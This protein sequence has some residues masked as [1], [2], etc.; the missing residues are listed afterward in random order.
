MP[1]ST[2]SF[3]AGTAL[4]AAVLCG[5]HGLSY[6]KHIEST[7]QDVKN[8]RD[9]PHEQACSVE[10]MRKLITT[11]QEQL[12][13]QRFWQAE[14]M[15]LVIKHI[16]V[17]TQEGKSD[18]LSVF[19]DN[20]LS[21][22]LVFVYEETKRYISQAGRDVHHEADNLMEV[23]FETINEVSEYSGAARR[24]MVEAFCARLIMLV[25]N[26]KIL[27]HTRMEAERTLNLMLEGCEDDDLT[28][29]GN[30]PVT[31]KLMQHLADIL[32]VAG[33]FEMQIA[34]TESLARMVTKSERRRRSPAWFPLQAISEAF[35]AIDDQRFDSD[36]RI[37]LNLLNES[38][39]ER[40]VCSFP[41]K[42]AFLG[43]FELRNPNEDKVSEFWV[44]FNAVSQS[45]TMY[46]ADEDTG[47]EEEGGLWETVTFSKEKV[48]EYLVNEDEKGFINLIVTLKDPASSILAFCG[49]DSRT[50]T[51]IF[52][53]RTDLADA[54]VLS[55]GSDKNAAP[56]ETPS[57]SRRSSVSKINVLVNRARNTSWG[58]SNMPQS[59]NDGYI[60]VGAHQ[61]LH[62]GK[63][64][65]TSGVMDADEA[66]ATPVRRKISIPLVPM[67][68]PTRTSLYS[69]ASSSVSSSGSV[70]CQGKQTNQGFVQ[71]KTPTG[72]HG[73]T[74]K[75][76][77]PLQVTVADKPS[78]SGTDSDHPKPQSRTPAKVSVTRNTIVCQSP[79]VSQ[80]ETE[81]KTP[82]LVANHLESASSDCDVVEQEVAV[83]KK[84]TKG[85]GDQVEISS[86]KKS[87]KQTTVNDAGKY[88]VKKGR[89]KKGKADQVVA[90]QSAPNELSQNV[91]EIPDTQ[92]QSLISQESEG[93]QGTQKTTGR[94]KGRKAATNPARD[95][96]K[97]TTRSS[98][99]S[100]AKDG[101]TA[102][103]MPQPL[104]TGSKSRGGKKFTL[105]SET[106]FLMDSSE[107]EEKNTG[108]KTR[109]KGK[110]AP[111]VSNKKSAVREM[112]E[113]EGAAPKSKGGQTKKRKKQEERKDLQDTG[114][115]SRKSEK[116]TNETQTKGKWASKK[117]IN[118]ISEPLMI[119]EEDN[120][121]Q[122]F[123][124][125]KT[126]VKGK[127]IRGVNDLKGDG[128]TTCNP[129]Y[130]PDPQEEQERQ[131]SRLPQ[132][133][134]KAAAQALAAENAE[135]CIPSSAPEERHVSSQIVP[136]SQP[137]RDFFRRSGRFPSPL[138][139]D[140]TE[141]STLSKGSSGPKLG[142]QVPQASSQSDETSELMVIKSKTKPETAKADSTSTSCNGKDP[143]DF[144]DSSSV[145]SFPVGSRKTPA[146]GS[147]DDGTSTKAQKGGEMTAAAKR[148]KGGRPVALCEE[149]GTEESSQDE[150][151]ENSHKFGL[152]N[153]GSAKSMDQGK[154]QRSAKGRKTSATS[155]HQQE[156]TET[157]DDAHE[158][159]RQS[160]R[161]KMKGK[162]DS[163][164]AYIQRIQK[165]T[166]ELAE[167]ASRMQDQEEEYPDIEVARDV[168]LVTEA[169]D[170]TDIRT[171]VKSV[172][173]SL[174]ERRMNKDVLKKPIQG[175]GKTLDRQDK[176]FDDE[177]DKE[178][179]CA[180]KKDPEVDDAECGPRRQSSSSSRKRK[181]KSISRS[182]D[183]E[184][185]G[186]VTSEPHKKTF[187][188]DI[189]RKAVE[190]AAGMST[191]SSRRSVR[192]SVKGD[193][194]LT[195]GEMSVDDMVSAHMESILGD[196]SSSIKKSTSKKAEDRMKEKR[197]ALHVEELE[198]DS[199]VLRHAE[200]SI[201][202]R[203]K[204]IVALRRSSSNM[205][206]D[207]ENNIDAEKVERKRSGDE[208]LHTSNDKSKRTTRSSMSFNQGDHALHDQVPSPKHHKERKSKYEK[209][210]LEQSDDDSMYD[211]ERDLQDLQASRKKMKQEK[212]KKQDSITNKSKK[213]TPKTTTDKTPPYSAKKKRSM[214]DNVEVHEEV[215]SRM[216]KAKPV[217][218]IDKMERSAL[219]SKVSKDRRTHFGSQIEDSDSEEIMETAT[220]TP[221]DETSTVVSVESFSS[222]C[223]D[224]LKSSRRGIAA[225]RTR[226]KV[227]KVD[228]TELENSSVGSDDH[229]DLQ[230][231]CRSAKKTCDKSTSDIYE[232]REETSSCCTTSFI[233][234]AV[235]ECSWLADKPK[236]KVSTYSKTRREVFGLAKITMN[237]DTVKKPGNKPQVKNANAP[238]KRKSK[239]L[240]DG[241][242]D[243]FPLYYYEEEKETKKTKKS[244]KKGTQQR[245]EPD[246]TIQVP[247]HQKML[248]KKPKSS[249]RRSLAD[250]MS[251]F[252]SSSI[253]HMYDS[254]QDLREDSDEGEE[255]DERGEEEKEEVEEEE[256]LITPAT[257]ALTIET[258]TSQLSC[259]NTP[260]SSTRTPRTPKQVSFV[261]ELESLG[262]DGEG[263]F[264]MDCP[265]SGPSKSIRPSESTLK[266][267]YANLLLDD[268]DE[269]IN[270]DIDED[271]SLE[272]N[273]HPEEED[274]SRSKDKNV[275][276]LNHSSKQISMLEP[277]ILFQANNL[278]DVGEQSE[279][280]GE[281]GISDHSISSSWG[282]NMDFPSMQMPEMFGFMRN[283]IKQKL[284]EKRTQTQKFTETAIQSTQRQMNKLF[285]ELHNAR[286]RGQSDFQ[287][288]LLTEL[289]GME[290]SLEKL[291]KIQAQNEHLLKQYAKKSTQ[292]VER[293]LSRVEELH[294]GFL[295]KGASLGE[296]VVESLQH[297]INK[298]MKA[299]L[300]KM[301]QDMQQEQMKKTMQSLFLMR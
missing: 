236:Q 118:G 222:M 158:K 136:N 64:V 14:I 182:L 252:G 67:I 250:C 277:R 122:D 8:S 215:Q 200:D 294:A 248:S 30:D 256:V 267:K 281:D 257:P 226:R 100:Q 117:I 49:N 186:E 63:H 9:Q 78:T 20:G 234:D 52:N 266:K 300:K 177:L 233:E 55:L 44:D 187:H 48:Q 72:L 138:L 57:S 171:F 40:S 161:R 214:E 249:C 173:K 42:K 282:H 139:S 217:T 21:E 206:Q 85:K 238:K 208:M 196:R 65:G 36:C 231:P 106:S 286:Q 195:E 223:K 111:K 88:N 12:P 284:T 115:S 10:M 269:N 109:G 29:V 31:A 128:M 205:H 235:S 92:S 1:V 162:L 35:L 225:G 28:W 61:E 66:K 23:L 79:M 164:D 53:Q 112:E 157:E 43:D 194:S 69:A 255:N 131:T 202:R 279:H 179:L 80:E 203:S 184:L 229:C 156:T 258:V 263:D 240:T 54:L 153:K 84:A 98:R 291:G 168:P 32:P 81:R 73:S 297:V 283:R 39:R 190:T 70:D 87:A 134:R 243:E 170:D 46:V 97:R 58:L 146:K 123:V 47:L 38:C 25:I 133:D 251:S 62:S 160:S 121:S 174:P 253:S 192:E 3:K 147:G 288:K 140:I 293:H 239:N 135:F 60:D 26:T 176:T 125:P 169:Y 172:M 159:P 104:Q 273:A 199:E 17:S 107:S 142:K 2:T 289:V 119:H 18:N 59:F 181:L 7:L 275:G 114:R 110:K 274:K 246:D 207:E 37:F 227:Q 244:T 71:P 193:E 209:P 148:K 76:K 74:K 296:N 51:I 191:K 204:T 129:M 163:E 212:S 201:S 221:P 245:N 101:D 213:Y 5:Q 24:L 102:S 292:H 91:T 224:L 242:E 127:Q 218:T 11:I 295:R 145:G 287:H 99:S 22:I 166:K 13:C 285:L 144:V 149:D 68:T 271:V 16:A 82:R 198:V 268:E 83:Q 143:Y 132:I 183:A 175:K 247:S 232:F 265:V 230:T 150:F 259:W 96:S 33:D 45:I 260:G 210:R 89:S 141:E 278:M 19:L 124:V 50:A 105:Y 270:E 95:G 165:E 180:E 211:Y 262:S 120:L 41:C 280:S 220:T 4:E 298:E 154:N 178:P 103:D 152:R 261:D 108:G 155:D 167:F 15:V 56:I 301:L 237:L 299:M 151:V 126:T 94:K 264:K 185:E 90:V 116:E 34:I 228:Y 216:T 188:K 254:S 197:V 77:T 290:G 219:T 189:S 113:S 27:F 93:S 130:N 276:Q 75:V 6:F 86:A 137:K 241:A 272:D